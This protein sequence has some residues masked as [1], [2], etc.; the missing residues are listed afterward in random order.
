LE[1]NNK[2]E[3]FN[4]DC[5]E[6]MKRYPD[7]YFDLAIVD[8][9]Y[10]DVFNT[11]NWE[12]TLA[13]QKAYKNRQDTLTNKKPTKEYFNEVIRVSKNQIIWGGNYFMLPIS[14]G[15]IFWLK[16]KQDNYF[17]DGE[18]A[19]TSFDR[20]LKCFDFLWSGMLQG[21]MKNKEKKIHPTQKPVSLYKWIYQNYAKKDFK[22]IDTHF[23]SGSN[24][25]AL[26]SMNKIEKMN[27]SLVACEIDKEYLDKSFERFK[28][29]E[30]QLVLF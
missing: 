13:K 3:V 27:M 20:V 28:E 23:G 1:W 18:L 16:G 2:I 4:E 30:S 14:R 25:I 15:W 7:N 6:V 8:P 26:D 24:G 11:D 22:I 19:W 9:P 21:N 10:M 29:Y 17:S 5:M 12:G